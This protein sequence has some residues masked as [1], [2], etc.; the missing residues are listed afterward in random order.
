MIVHFTGSIRE[1]ETDTT[2]LQHA[3]DAIHDHGAALARSWL[4]AAIARH[5]AK[6]LQRD[7]SDYVKQNIDAIKRAD[8]VIIDATHQSFSHGYQLMAALSNKKPTLVITRDELV[9]K[10][11]LGGL[12]DTL[13][14][15]E[16]YKTKDEL[17]KIIKSFLT[18]NTVYT[19]DLRFNMFLTRDIV[20]YLEEHAQETGRSR[21]EIIRA[22]IKKQVEEHR[23]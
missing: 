12:A 2:N 22:L 21:S 5:K 20:K 6:R 19:K 14:S 3:I 15:L 23:S 11:Y 17:T 10:E 13:L 18:R 4:D 8:V 16:V 9:T 7:W 1:F